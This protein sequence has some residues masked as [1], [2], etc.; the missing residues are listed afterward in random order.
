MPAATL[1]LHGGARDGTTEDIE[2]PWPRNYVIVE[3]PD[4][5]E[6]TYFVREDLANADW[7]SDEAAE[8]LDPGSD[9]TGPPG[10]PGEDG[11]PGELGPE[12]PPGPPG[13]QGPPGPPFTPRGAWDPDTTYDLWDIVDHEGSSYYTIT[14]MV[15]ATEPPDPMYWALLAQGGTGGSGD[16][17]GNIDGGH[18]DSTYAATPLIDGGGI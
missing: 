3:N 4:E 7:L 2:Q 14:D 6:A 13:P 5:T 15:V 9:A 12:G 1:T 11:A 8:I 10:T 18:P 16:G 17:G